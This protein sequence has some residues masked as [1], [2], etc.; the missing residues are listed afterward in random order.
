[1]KKCPKCSVVFEGY[2]TYCPDDGAIL[3]E[4]GVSPAYYTPTQVI[5]TPAISPA[6]REKSP[7]IYVLLGAMAATILALGIVL[8]VTSGGGNKSVEPNREQSATNTSPSA[9]TSGSR[10]GEQPAPADEELPITVSHAQG[11]MTRWKNSQNSKN[12]P[13]YRSLYAPTFVGIKDTEDGRSQRQDY[14]E[15][16]SDRGKMVANFTNVEM[17]EPNYTQQGSTVVVTFRQQWQSL[18]HCDVGKK[19]ITI[20]MFPGGPKIISERIVNPVNCYT[21]I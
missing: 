20:K 17:Q 15:W 18:R 10:N 2:E 11:L 19:T 13:V 16:M 12:F 6:V 5:N 4:D 21:P 3:V 14:R 8:Y 1:M 9:P 7:L